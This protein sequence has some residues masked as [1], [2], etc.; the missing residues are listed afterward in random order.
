MYRI[1]GSNY[2]TIP[3]WNGPWNPNEVSWGPGW[4]FIGEGKSTRTFDIDEYYETVLIIWHADSLFNSDA[5]EDLTSG[6]AFAV[7]EYGSSSSYNWVT[8]GLKNSDTDEWSEPYYFKGH[9]DDL[10]A[11]TTEWYGFSLFSMPNDSL[12]N[13]TDRQLKLTLVS[14]LKGDA[15]G[16]NDVDL[17][18]VSTVLQMSEGQSPFLNMGA[19]IDGDGKIGMA[20]AIYSLEIVSGQR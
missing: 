20:E 9:P 3:S 5:I 19:D 13:D 1:F 14:K 8:S 11:R 2:Y 17:A 16:D 6:T 15:D 7:D 18:G 4:A 10:Y 12:D